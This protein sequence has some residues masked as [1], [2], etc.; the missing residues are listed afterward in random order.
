[1]TYPLSN[2][3]ERIICHI[4]LLILQ[5]VNTEE[6]NTPDKIMEGVWLAK[7]AGYEGGDEGE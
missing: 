6:F 7:S 3:S 5:K 2:T 4:I 1:M